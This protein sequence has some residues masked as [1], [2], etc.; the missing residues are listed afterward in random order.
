MLRRFWRSSSLHLSQ[1]VRNETQASSLFTTTYGVSSSPASGNLTLASGAPSSGGVQ[2]ITPTYVGSY[3]PTVKADTGSGTQSAGKFKSLSAMPASEVKNHA[4]L[5]WGDKGVSTAHPNLFSPSSAFGASTPAFRASRVPT[6]GASINSPFSFGFS[7]A[8][9]QSKSPFCKR[10]F[11]SSAIP[12][13]ACSSGAYTFAEVAE[14]VG[15]SVVDITVGTDLGMTAPGSGVLVSENTVITCA[16]LV[17]NINR[18]DDKKYVA[19]KKQVQMTSSTGLRIN[20]VV[21]KVDYTNGLALVTLESGV[22]CPTAKFG[23]TYKVRR[24]EFVCAIGSPCASPNSLTAGVISHA[25]RFD[26]ELGMPSLG[27]HFIQTDC[28]FNS[29][30][31]GGPLCNY[32]GEIIGIMYFAKSGTPFFKLIVQGLAFAIPIGVAWEGLGLDS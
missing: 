13:P 17:L 15:P 29:G 11:G 22:K 19:S 3:S 6:F 18:M 4:G 23:L 32:K 28:A 9:G 24:G 7:P 25:E 5:S 20:G 1:M 14:A 31:E 26:Y 10:T 16:H 27:R 12:G 8:F 30:N 21:G 2:A